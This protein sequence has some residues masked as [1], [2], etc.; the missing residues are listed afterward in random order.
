MRASTPELRALLAGNQFVK[1]NLFTLTLISGV[2]YFWTDADVDVVVR[3][4]SQVFSSSGPSISGVQYK[5][6]RGLQVDNYDLTA[7][8]KDTDTLAGVPWPVAVR[9]GAL[10]G[11]GM[12]IEKAFLPAW[13][14]SAE[15]LQIFAGE[16]VNPAYVDLAVT[17]T[18]KSDADYLNTMVPRLLF[19]AGCAHTLFDAGCTVSK[20]AYTFNGSISELSSQAAF[21]TNLTQADDYFSRGRLMFTSGA[22]AGVR[23]AVKSF[24]HSQGRIELSF[25]MLEPL[26]VGDSFTITAGCDKS[27]G[28]NGCAKFNNLPNFKGTPYIPKPEAI[29]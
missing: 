19:Q 7:L 11:A 26:A 4:T 23:R 9:S 10:D 2:Q 16:V 29:L 8:V 28:A 15:T 22:N 27:Q 14:Q 5:L 24:A 12:L 25:P 6:V 17:L 20:A 21:F 18:V 13:G 1:C 3:A